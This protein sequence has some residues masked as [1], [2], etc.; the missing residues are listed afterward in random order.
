MPLICDTYPIFLSNNELAKISR[1]AGN[2]KYRI[3]EIT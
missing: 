3:V 2:S 1:L